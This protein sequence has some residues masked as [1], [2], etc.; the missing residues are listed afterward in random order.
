MAMER[1]IVGLGGG[2]D[3]PEQTD[4]LNDYVLG[5][6]GKERPRMLWVPT[7]VGDDAS[8]SLWFYERFAN[9]AELQSLPTFPWPPENLRDL[10][11]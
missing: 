5:I 4:L 11:L 7:A 9:R 2:G 3:T 8:V 6:V 10:I 1:H